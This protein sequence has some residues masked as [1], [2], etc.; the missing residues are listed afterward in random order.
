MDFSLFSKK[1]H[2]FL[3]CKRLRVIESS[4]FPPKPLDFFLHDLRDLDNQNNKLFSDS[5]SNKRATVVHWLSF[6]VG[7]VWRKGIYQISSHKRHLQA[8]EG[9]AFFICE[10]RKKRHHLLETGIYFALE[11]FSFVSLVFRIG[12]VQ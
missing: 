8:N 6:L 3:T 1:Q 2:A 4:W 11:F 9:P 10:K 12:I 5:S 7:L